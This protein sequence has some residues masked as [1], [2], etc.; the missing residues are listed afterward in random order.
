MWLNTPPGGGR[1]REGHLEGG[2]ISKEDK[3]GTFGGESS[4]GDVGRG[5]GEGITWTVLPDSPVCVCNDISQ[6]RDT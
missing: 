2:K 4:G 3:M 1:V 6:K 5:G